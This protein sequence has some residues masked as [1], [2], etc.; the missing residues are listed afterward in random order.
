MVCEI[1]EDT[2]CLDCGSECPGFKTH[3]WRNICQMCKCPRDCHDLRFKGY[4]TAGEKLGLN[5]EQLENLKLNLHNKY[6]ILEKGFTWQPSGLSLEEI[7]LFFE[8]YP[9]DQI[10]R[11]GSHGE[12][13]REK[14]LIYQIPKQDVCLD[15]CRFIKTNEAREEYEKFIN[16]RNMNALDIGI[17]KV[18]NKDPNLECEY[19][20]K[21][22]ELDT[23]QV[24]ASLVLQSNNNENSIAWH[25]SCFCC[26]KCNEILVDLVYCVKDNNIYCLRHYA[27]EL[28]PR[29]SGCDE[30]CTN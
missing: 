17:C 20:Q 12:K 7:L 19:C 11:L 5:D 10:P 9:Q 27:E 16:D 26:H 14:A 24:N 25:P 2:L 23:V 18:N 13:W 15:N 29:C 4:V 22:I 8:N 30:V 21:T 28:V 3:E 1:D 6:S